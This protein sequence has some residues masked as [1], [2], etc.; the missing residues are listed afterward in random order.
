MSFNPNLGLSCVPFLAWTLKSHSALLH[1]DWEEL[2]VFVV[3]VGMKTS[4]EQA[5]HPGRKSF[6]Q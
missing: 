5:S 4:D 1:S 6:K 2:M 3:G